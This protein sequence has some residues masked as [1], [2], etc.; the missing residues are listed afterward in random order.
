MVRTDVITKDEEVEV[1]NDG[2]YLGTPSFQAGSYYA[3]AIRI[4]LND[5]IREN[6]FKLIKNDN[7]EDSDVIA[8]GD[9]DGVAIDWKSSEGYSRLSQSQANANPVATSKLLN[10]GTITPQDLLA[11]T[12]ISDINALINFNIYYEL[13]NA[14]SERIS[15]Y[16]VGKSVSTSY[17]DL[18]IKVYDESKANNDSITNLTSKVGANE[19]AIATNAENIATNSSNIEELGTS[20]EEFKTSTNSALSNKV[21]TYTLNTELNKKISK[22][23]E[24]GF[25]YSPNSDRYN[26][27]GEVEVRTDVIT[28]QYKKLYKGTGEQLIEYNDPSYYYEEYSYIDTMYHGLPVYIQ[29]ISDSAVTVN[30]NLNASSSTDPDYEYK[31]D[32]NNV[33]I[34]PGEGYLWERVQEDYD[35]EG[36]C[37]RFTTGAPSQVVLYSEETEFVEINYVDLA[38]QVST[39]ESNIAALTETVADHEER[40][41][42]VETFFE[43]AEGETLDTALDTLVEIQKYITD[44]GSAADEMVKDI[45]DHE[46]RIK[47]IEDAP[48]ATTANVATA[49]GEAIADAEG[50]VNALK[51]GVEDGTVVAAKATEAYDYTAD[52][53]IDTAIKAASK[54]GTD[55]AA[56]VEA[57]VKDGTIVAAKATVAAVANDLSA[58]LDEEIAG[59]IAT[60]KSGAEATAAADAT[61]KANKAKDEAIAATSASINGMSIAGEDF[62]VK[63][64]SKISITPIEDSNSEYPGFTIGVD[65]T[66]IYTV[67]FNNNSLY[68]KTY[69]DYEAGVSGTEIATFAEIATTGSIYDVTEGSNVSTGTDAGTEYLIFN[70]GTSTTII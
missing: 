53:A 63:N 59:L 8:F 38:N 66:D 18:V 24:T 43:T 36:F 33:S 3:A 69:S 19:S 7:F 39:N 6:G 27:S 11:I 58:A 44:E 42:K 26:D 48:Y 61:S 65:P 67:S 64:G 45:A 12:G 52:V 21:S 47:A 49:K 51:T 55:A 1:G 68:A 30:C 56:A 5:D 25:L 40:I 13:N 17:S 54:A 60:A 41:T 28:E 20:L 4:S 37:I 29:N 9:Y 57:G 46:D 15:F 35:N 32:V 14:G 62:T 10:E 50:K 70:C 16:T 23:Y 2:E 22:V 34:L 31:S